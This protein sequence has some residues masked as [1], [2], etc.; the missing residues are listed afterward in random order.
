MKRLVLALLSM[1]PSSA[2]DGRC[3]CRGQHGLQAS[4][5][6]EFR[7]HGTEWKNKILGTALWNYTGTVLGNVTGT[8]AGNCAGTA[9]GSMPPFTA[10]HR[11]EEAAGH[12]AKVGYF[13]TAVGSPRASVCCHV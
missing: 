6:E 9:I 1:A 11:G 2:K 13:T 7:V 4:L 8:V 10:K 3:Q 12:Q 5:E